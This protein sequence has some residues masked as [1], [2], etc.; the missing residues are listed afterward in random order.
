MAQIAAFDD[1]KVNRRFREAAGG[2]GGRTDFLVGE[3]GVPNLP[4]VF[5]AESPPARTIP[6]HYH[7]VDEYQV[8]MSG[9]GW[10]GKHRLIIHGV[11]FARA[12]TPYG[13]I[14]PEKDGLS[15]LTLRTQA[16]GP[17][18]MVPEH[19]E[20]LKRM[21]NRRPYQGTEA[22]V[23]GGPDDVSIRLLS[24]L[25]EGGGA[26]AHA[27][28]LKPNARA[29]APDHALSNGQF[30]V[31][32]RGGLVHQGKLHNALTVAFVKPD[33]P[34]FELAAGTEGADV[35]VLDMPRNAES[36]AH[37][38]AQS[39]KFRVWQCAL[40][41]FT[42]DEAKGIPDEGIAPGTRWEDVPETW[43]CPDCAAGK[44]DFEMEVVG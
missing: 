9:S 21:P 31:V 22:P 38:P 13:P 43:T 35:L 30:L 18:R 20:T 10:F 15:F 3:V 8:P 12:Y 36:A 41:A 39:T 24:T 23:F 40:C 16:A 44:A 2:L 27:V 11:H 29:A 26:T 5:L 34:R 28:S 19:S 33:E 17:I 37:K 25:K 6:P 7:D 32:V 42:Y 1:V 4:Q 14:A